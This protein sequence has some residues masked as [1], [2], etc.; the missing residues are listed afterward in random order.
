MCLCVCASVSALTVD[1]F[2]ANTQDLVQGSTLT[3][4]WMSSKFKVIGQGHQVEKRDFQSFTL[5][6]TY[7]DCTES[8]CYDMRRHVTS[9]CDV[10]MSQRDT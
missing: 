8:F 9:R 3:I 2:D 6:V 1:P 10:M 5:G 4:S 7:V